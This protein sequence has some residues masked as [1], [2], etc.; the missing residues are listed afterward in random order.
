MIYI[1]VFLCGWICA[2][3]WNSVARSKREETFNLY[4]DNAMDDLKKFQQSVHSELYK[5]NE[6]FAKMNISK[7]LLEALKDILKEKQ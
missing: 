1:L 5:A 7:L 3:I 4:R 2:H 6:E